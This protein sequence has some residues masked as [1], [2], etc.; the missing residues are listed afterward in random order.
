MLAH[1]AVARI[2]DPAARAE[3]ALRCG[4]ALAISAYG[5]A[6]IAVCRLALDDEPAHSGAGGDAAAVPSET[7]A[8]LEAE[9][10]GAAGLDSRTMPLH[11][12][13]VARCRARPPGLPLWR[14]IE[15]AADTF[16]GRPARHSLAH[17]WPLLEDGTLAAETDSVL[18]TVAGLYADR[19]RGTGRRPGDE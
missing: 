3:A 4:R 1:E 2:A 15:A 6:A 17:L 13:F 10:A 9:V 18:L 16:D 14:V 5:A 19:Q 8:R 11:R 12:E 7:R